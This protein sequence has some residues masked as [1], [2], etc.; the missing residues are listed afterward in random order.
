[1][2]YIFLFVTFFYITL[3]LA[4][5][6]D[7]VKVKDSVMVN[8]KDLF[9]ADYSNQLNIKF[10]VSNEL[11][12]YFI[13]LE[14]ITIE[15]LPNLGIRYALVF[16]YKFLSISAGIRANPSKESKEEK[17]ESDLF[18]LSAT[19]LFDKWSHRFTFSRVKGY[20]VGNS[21]DFSP[22]FTEGNRFLQFPDLK[23]HLFSGTSA[24]KLNDNYSIKAT[25]SQ[26]EIQL[27]SAGS[28]VPSI[29]Y[30]FYLFNGADKFIDG[31]GNQII[32][33]TYS[34]YRGVNIVFN[35][36]YYYTFVMKKWFVNLYAAPGIGVDFFR[37]TFYNP[38]N[39]TYTIN[40]SDFVFSIQ[41]GAGIG[42][43][44]SKYYFGINYLNRYT[45]EYGNQTDSQIKTLKNSFFI[46]FGYR[47]KAPKQISVPVEYIEKK[48]P[49]L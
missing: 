30:W 35:I 19:F 37:E 47:F 45:N 4:Q 23:T 21:S 31:E 6:D 2:K 29:D 33:M 43:N 42:Y 16:N 9:I 38:Q 18:E 26:T 24:Y 7:K 40:Q 34:D 8:E 28:L 14:E 10:E 44:S 12:N 27:K 46:F 11:K 5:E 20:Y 3:T 1:M 17:G 48:I 49:I 41:G 22:Y 15:L 36:G 13:P 32:R 25:Q 39:T